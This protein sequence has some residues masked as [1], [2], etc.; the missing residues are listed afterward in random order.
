MFV[1]SKIDFSHIL[2]SKWT[3]I[4]ILSNFDHF[5]GKICEKSIFDPTNI[6]NLL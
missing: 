6:Q 4:A 3:K 5:E 1:G 2:P